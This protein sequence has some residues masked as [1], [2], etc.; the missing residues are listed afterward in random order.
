MLVASAAA[1]LPTHTLFHPPGC[2]GGYK[3]FNPSGLDKIR[4]LQKGLGTLMFLWSKI[5]IGTTKS[6]EEAKWLW[7]RVKPGD[8]EQKVVQSPEGGDT[9]TCRAAFGA[10][11]TAL[12]LTPGCTGGH[13]CFDPSDL[14]IIK[15]RQ[16]INLR[17]FSLKISG[18]KEKI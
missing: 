1:D 9:K 2:T 3:Y 10:L 5:W 7:P 11:G 15:I 6:L 18:K 8:G 14:G 17:S 13:N 16:S 12:S 4:V